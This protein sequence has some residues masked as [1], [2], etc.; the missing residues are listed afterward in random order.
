LLNKVV[1]RE[2]SIVSDKPGT[3]RDA[4]DTVI[5]HGDRTLT[6]I[7]TAGIRRRGR[8]EFGV[9]K[10]SV[11]RALRAVARADVALIVIDA[12]EGVTAQDTHLAGYA[13]QAGR[14]CVL[15]LNKWDL[16]P[17]DAVTA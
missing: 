8:I 11:I 12:S 10:Y 3:T 13:R 16:V 5:Q 9:E 1:G 6:L 14:G 2:R 17:R 7:D 15:V 4:I